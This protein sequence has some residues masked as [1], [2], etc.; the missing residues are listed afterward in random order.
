MARVTLGDEGTQLTQA[1]QES[2]VQESEEL[3]SALDAAARHVMVHAGDV[4]AV[5][6]AIALLGRI[7]HIRRQLLIY[8]AW[9]DDFVDSENGDTD[10]D[11]A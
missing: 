4:Q 3:T 10:Q 9:T 5:I 7:D 2:V 8:S 1:G 11:H 6:D